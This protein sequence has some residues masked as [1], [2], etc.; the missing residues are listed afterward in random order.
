MNLEVAR[1]ALLDGLSA[2]VARRSLIDY[3]TLM[4]PR[5]IPARHLDLIAEHLEKL[6]RREITRLCVTLPPRHGKTRLIS[7]LFASW[8]VGKHSDHDVILASYGSELAEGN[9]RAVRTLVTD[10]RFP[11]SGV[12]LR[13]DSRSVGRWQTEQGGTLVAVGVGAGLT[14]RGGNLIVCDDLVKD[15]EAA[16]SEAV[17]ASTRAWYGDVLQTRAAPDAV[18][19]MVGTRWHDADILSDVVDRDGWVTI[20]LPLI[21]EGEGDALNRPAG[22]WLWPQRFGPDDVP[23]VERGEISSRSFEAL[24]Q[25]RPAPAEGAL[26]KASWFENRF[27]SLPKAVPINQRLVEISQILGREEIAR[28]QRPRSITVVAGIDCASKT[29]IAND[30]SAIVTVAFDGQDYYILDVVRERLEFSELIGRVAESYWRHRPSILYVEEASAGI[31]IVQVLKAQT[32]IP[33]VGV[34]PRGSKIARAEAITP[35]WESG[36][37]KLPQYAPWIDAYVQE[38]LRFPYAGKHDDQI[39][40]TCLAI[41]N[42]RLRS[43]ARVDWSTQYQ[44]LMAR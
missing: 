20:N 2:S 30:F 6:E 28:R 16:E 19:V 24:Y 29:G 5:F 9:S 10:D 1:P 18:R 21:S 32:G 41:Y 36:R 14:G 31:Q 13:E 26:F 35:L 12:S 33:V 44:P 23:S 42:A 3:C 27:D 15:R 22:E 38:F 7:Q 43:R 40:A 25:Q 39:D 34:T 37:I 8:Y 17:R 11:F 4:D